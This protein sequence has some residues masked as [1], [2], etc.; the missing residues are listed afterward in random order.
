VRLSRIGLLS[1]SNRQAGFT[2]ITAIFLL[3]V[4]ATLSVYILNLRNVQQQTLVFGV[5]GARAMQAART[6][7]EWG[8]YQSIKAGSCDDEIFTAP[9]AAL[10]AFTITVTCTESAHTEGFTEIKAFQLR[11][12]AQ[13]GNYGTLDYV[14]R[15]MEA[16]VSKP[17]P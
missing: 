1:Q 9:D 7:I 16:L 4:V 6:G 11:A 2:L 15:L 12:V 17:P 3:V 5:Q 8:I 13:T 10:S 14:S